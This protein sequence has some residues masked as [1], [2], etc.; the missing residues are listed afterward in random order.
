MKTWKQTYYNK[1]FRDAENSTGSVIFQAQKFEFMEG[2]MAT[3][4]AIGLPDTSPF[5][6]AD[7]IPLPKDP[8]VKAQAQEESEDNSE[9]EEGAKS[10]E[11]RELSHQIDSHTVVLNED[12]PATTVPSVTKGA[13]QLALGSDPP[14]TSEA[15]LIDPVA[16]DNL[17]T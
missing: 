13:T 7:Q 2:W 5:K 10:F 14:V 3:M 17:N 4:N 1:G 6:S 16:P 8:K 11:M 12:N 9:E 15:P